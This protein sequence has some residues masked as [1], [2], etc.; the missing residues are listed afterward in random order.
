MCWVASGHAAARRD[1]VDQFEVQMRTLNHEQA[2]ATAQ[3]ILAQASAAQ[4]PR[5]QELVEAHC[6]VG[7][8]YLAL[9]NTASAETSFTTALA[10]GEQQL[11]PSSARLAEPL[12]HLGMLYARTQRHAE[13]VQ[14]LERA[15]ILSRRNAGLYDPSQARILKE[16]GESYTTLGALADAQRHY[17]YLRSVAEHAYGAEDVRIVATLCEV[18]DWYSRVGDGQTARLLYRRAIELVEAARGKRSTELIAPLHGF[19]RTY[20]RDLLNPRAA[21]ARRQASSVSFGQS[22][23]FDEDE[24]LGPYGPQ[25]LSS[26][27]EK[28]LQR[29]VD[30][31][32]QPSQ[33]A[34]ALRNALIALADWFQIK[35]EERKSMALYL[36]AARLAGPDGELL[37]SSTSL[38]MPALLYYLTPLGA[39]R[40]PN[41][42]AEELEAHSVLVEFTVTAKG[43]VENPTVVE[44]DASERHVKQTLAALEKARYR[45]RFV[46]GEPV[47]TTGVRYRQVFRTLKKSARVFLQMGPAQAAARQ[48]L[49]A[50]SAPA[51]RASLAL[52][53]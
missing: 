47:A 24:D 9:D 29:A 51:L 40:F 48:A 27:G 3:E 35:Q 25:K 52:S 34:L 31:L 17:E 2:L 1:A 26:D 19:A 13:A 8:A 10:I 32:E 49:A 43:R 44:T 22:P 18:A 53:S 30:I 45:P 33:D 36:R 20:T 38:Q 50:R 16:L 28:A 12:T 41:R 39:N 6:L 11:G 5:P 46:N 7:R 14:T 15:L 42:S 4:P 23:M 21:E 37:E